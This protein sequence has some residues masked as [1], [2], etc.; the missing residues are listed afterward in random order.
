MKV[1]GKRY[2]D[3]TNLSLPLQTA[4]WAR[5]N[6]TPIALVVLAYAEG[7]DPNLALTAKIKSGKQSEIQSRCQTM[8]SRVVSRCGG[9]P[10]I[11]NGDLLRDEVAPNMKVSYLHRTAKDTSRS[12]I[13]SLFLG[14]GQGAK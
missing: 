7:K 4:S 3:S 1:I 2:L 14:I 13:L 11:Q 9:L 6:V 12:E 8:A 5:C 10:E